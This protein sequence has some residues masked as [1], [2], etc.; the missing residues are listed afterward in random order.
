MKKGFTQIHRFKK[1]SNK[2][3]KQSAIE[4]MRSERI[5]VYRYLRAERCLRQ[6]NST[7]KLE[8]YH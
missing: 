1:I 4:D 7:L 8:V 2:D 6:F 5:P 3:A